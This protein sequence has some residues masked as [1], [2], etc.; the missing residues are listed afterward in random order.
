MFFFLP[1]PN[2][3]R[4]ATYT[5]CQVHL[6][7]RLPLPPSRHSATIAVDARRR[8][9]ARTTNLSPW[10]VRDTLPKPPTVRLLQE[11][12]QPGSEPRGRA[13][14][15]STG[16]AASQH[17]RC[18]RGGGVHITRFHPPGVPWGERTNHHGAA[19]SVVTSD[20]GRSWRDGPPMGD[21][22]PS[23]MPKRL[24]KDPGRRFGFAIV[25]LCRH[26]YDH[27]E[28]PNVKVTGVGILV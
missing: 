26:D 11:E 16:L 15:R 28:V 25:E 10:M 4:L 2:K 7:P 24:S 19:C 22:F 1:L 17:G 9:L 13:R 23:T 21:L 27:R 6:P 3:S 8:L 18:S 20:R 12:A 5:C 14:G